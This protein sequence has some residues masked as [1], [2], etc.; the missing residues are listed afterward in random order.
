MN[1]VDFLVIVIMLLS[2]LL[3]VMRGFTREVLTIVAWIG[4]ALA[5][6]FGLP[7]ATPL[8]EKMFESPSMARIV[9]GA[10]LGLV[11][12]IILSLISNQIG[13]AIKRSGLGPIDRSLGAFFGAAR[14]A[15][16]V[17]LI[18][19]LL[20]SLMQPLPAWME[21][22]KLE[23]LLAEG[24]DYLKSIAPSEIAG[25]LPNKAEDVLPNDKNE[26]EVPD[27]LPGAPLPPEP[28][29]GYHDKERNG[30]N[31]LLDNTA[32]LPPPPPPPAA[33]TK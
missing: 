32:P 11:T 23:P 26:T 18:Y 8:F 16:L 25:V 20:E 4:A 29:H 19:I 27:A 7:V 28:G 17:C 1:S 2:I 13:K 5:V 15:I 33:G 22:A 10:V 21:Q 12:L 31:D 3:A 9:A 14:G 6:M 30:M 24:A